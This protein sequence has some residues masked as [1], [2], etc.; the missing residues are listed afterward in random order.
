MMITTGPA[1]WL[2]GMEV[3]Q[4]SQYVILATG[5]GSRH[6]K[7]VVELR[8]WL[9]TFISYQL[10]PKQAGESWMAEVWWEMRKCC[11]FGRV[12]KKSEYA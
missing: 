11:R 3:L 2:T 6:H 10:D 1:G 9:S 4:L 5:C 12:G 7:R 8:Q